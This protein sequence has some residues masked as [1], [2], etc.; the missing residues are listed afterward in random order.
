MNNLL[1]VSYFSGYY[2]HVPYTIVIIILVITIMVLLYFRCRKS[3][4][5]SDLSITHFPPPTRAQYKTVPT[6][7][8]HADKI[9][10]SMPNIETKNLIL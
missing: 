2:Y 5:Q 7:K 4:R 8:Q 6:Y 1:T 9:I 3:R 10:S